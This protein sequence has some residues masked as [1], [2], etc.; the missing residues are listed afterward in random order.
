MEHRRGSP[1]QWRITTAGIPESGVAEVAAT[2]AER[3]CIGGCRIHVMQVRPRQHRDHEADGRVAAAA[4]RRLGRPNQL[5]HAQDLRDVDDGAEARAL[6]ELED[7]HRRALLGLFQ[8]RVRTTVG[9]VGLQT[10][11]AQRLVVEHDLH[12]D[13]GGRRRVLRHAATQQVFVGLRGGLG[14]GLG[15]PG[16]SDSGSGSLPPGRQRRRR[17]RSQRS[18]IKPSF[19]QQALHLLPQ[20]LPA[21][22]RDKPCLGAAV[23]HVPNKLRI[24]VVVKLPHR[25]HEVGSREPVHV[26]LADAREG[27]VEVV[28]V[29]TDKLSKVYHRLVFRCVHFAVLHELHI[30]AIIAEFPDHKKLEVKGV[31]EGRGRTYPLGW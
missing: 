13:A 15:A 2:E 25:Q 14:I 4:A 16:P 11:V 10:D 7:Q 28:Q 5:L 18:S 19:V 21:L 3:A 27:L 29:L 31:R 26:V 22:P 6:A 1:R 9:D 30:V 8:Q 12:V 20:C 23:Q 17:S 24:S